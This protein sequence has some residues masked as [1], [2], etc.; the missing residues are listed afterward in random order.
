MYWTLSLLELAVF[1]S[2]MYPVQLPPA[3]SAAPEGGQHFCLTKRKIQA[4]PW[5]RPHNSQPESP[6]HCHLIYLL[7]LQA[8]RMA[9]F[10]LRLGLSPLWVRHRAIVWGLTS[11]W[12]W[13]RAW[14]QCGTRN[15]KGPTFTKKHWFLLKPIKSSTLLPNCTRTTI[16]FW[17]VALVCWDPEENPAWA[18]LVWGFTTW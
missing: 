16:T 7:P 13:C 14:S 4:S 9:S 10:L 2:P 1:F 18:N 6:Y 12:S 17:S 5:Q 8:T 3:E 15:F 11:A